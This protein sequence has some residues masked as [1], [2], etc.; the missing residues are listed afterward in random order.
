MSQPSRSFLAASALPI[1]FLALAAL[2]RLDPW[3]A[4]DPV[5]PRRPTPAWAVDPAPVRSPSLRP[6]IRV[7]AYTYECSDCH[8]LFP[9]PPETVRDLTQHREISREHGMNRRCF[10][11]HH[12][13]ERDAFVDDRGAAIP[14]AEP[15]LLCAKCHGPVYRDWTHGVHGRS[16]GFW[17]ADLGPMRR[18]KCIECHDPHTPAF[19]PLRPAPGPRTLRMGDPVRKEDH[20]EDIRNPLIVH[21][22]SDGEEHR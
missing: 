8:D 13:T 21:R 7:A 15:Q 22:E 11:C 19:Q 9:S 6:E 5:E 20:G 12:V 17:R 16:N 18:L 14:W 1:A 3:P 2:F 10:N 4:E